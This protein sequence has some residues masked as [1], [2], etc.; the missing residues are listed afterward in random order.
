M[1]YIKLDENKEIIDKK[2][3][4]FFA[5]IKDKFKKIR[6]EKNE[7]KTLIVIKDV[8][9]KTLNALSKYIKKNCINRVCISNNLLTNSTFMNYI[10]KENVRILDGKWLFKHLASNCADYICK[11]KKESLG[12]QEISF[13]SNGISDI[14][15][16]NIKDISSKVRILNVITQDEKKFRKIEKELYEQ[17]GI[18]LNMNNNYK[19]S[20][21][22]SD[23]IFNF[24]FSEEEINKYSLPKRTCIINFNESIK[25][26]IKSFQ[27]INVDFFEIPMPRKYL[28][29]SIYLNDFDNSIL[30][31][32]YIYKNTSSKNIINEIIKDGVNISFLS[33]KSGRIRKN[34]YLNLSKKIAN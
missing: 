15:V 32:S 2:N 26:N 14:I 8:N 19:K 18:I 24:D 4:N 33:G 29:N 16:E 1:I 27:G 7:D 10:R 13:L 9:S 12:Y 23:I 21:M 3:I 17:K 20:L 25:I 34:E 28:K 31:E 5:K 22:K 30:Y 11:C 6:E